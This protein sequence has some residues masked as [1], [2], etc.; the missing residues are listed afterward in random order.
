MKNLKTYTFQITPELHELL[1][2]D[3]KKKQRTQSATIRYVLENYLK[4]LEVAQ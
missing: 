4:N 1:K 3:A 2:E